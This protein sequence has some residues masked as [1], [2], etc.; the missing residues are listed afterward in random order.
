MQIGSTTPSCSNVGGSGSVAVLAMVRSSVEPGWLAGAA[1]LRPLAMVSATL[2]T[3]I[4]VMLVLR[5]EVRSEVRSCGVRA[6]ASIGGPR[7]LLAHE[8][9]TGSRRTAGDSS[10]GRQHGCSPAPSC[11]QRVLV[12]QISGKSQARLRDQ[13]DSRTALRIRTRL[14]PMPFQDDVA[15]ECSN[16]D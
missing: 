10:K 14:G 4:G 9:Q 15:A 8:H 13:M 3:D 12:G 2:S 6:F 5:F 7:R 16:V 1:T 11:R